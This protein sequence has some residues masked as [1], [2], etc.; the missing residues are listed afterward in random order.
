MKVIFE[1]FFFFYSDFFF[2]FLILFYSFQENG[3]YDTGSKR[4]F[5]LMFLRN[6]KAKAT[7]PY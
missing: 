1:V 2:P 6:T 7:K 4:L 3:L 5:C